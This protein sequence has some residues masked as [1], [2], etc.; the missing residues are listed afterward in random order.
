[1]D[2]LENDSLSHEKYFI[3]MRISMRVIL[4][5]LMNDIENKGQL[6]GALIM[7]GVKVINANK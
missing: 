6:S 1:M 2:L 5:K 7:S 4:K 3:Q